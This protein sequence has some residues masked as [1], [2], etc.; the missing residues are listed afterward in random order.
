MWA[1]FEIIIG[2]DLAP[3]PDQLDTPGTKWTANVTWT[4][5]DWLVYDRDY[6]VY[7]TAYDTPW[8]YTECSFDIRVEDRHAP[9]GTRLKRQLL[10]RE[11]AACQL[12]GAV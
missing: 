9:Q 12:A 4:T 8:N 10:A 2:T 3:V 6:T 5:P 1:H 7:A 11:A